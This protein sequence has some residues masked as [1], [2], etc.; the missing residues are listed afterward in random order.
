MRA[1]L[2]VG[3]WA[4]VRALLVRR[5]AR[6]TLGGP[7]RT[8]KK[9]RVRAREEAVEATELEIQRMGGS[10]E[11]QFAAG[12]KAGKAFDANSSWNLRMAGMAS[13]SVGAPLLRMQACDS[14]AYA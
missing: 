9:A 7:G 13:R 11:E 2:I 14:C 10:K 8:G 3:A 5:A 6:A 4:F 1:C 12:I